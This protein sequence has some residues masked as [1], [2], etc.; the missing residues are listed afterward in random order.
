MSINRTPDFKEVLEAI[1]NNVEFL[2]A[3]YRVKSGKN[4]KLLLKK[5]VTFK[6]EWSDFESALRKLVV[7]ITKMKIFLVENRKDY[8]NLL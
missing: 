1:K 7:T 4:S 8:I 2:D 6:N 5:R 3:D